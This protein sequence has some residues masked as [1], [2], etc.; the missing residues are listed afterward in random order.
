MPTENFPVMDIEI[1]EFCADDGMFPPSV[2]SQFFPCEAVETSTDQTTEP[3][4]P[5]PVANALALLVT[6]VGLNWA[7]ATIQVPIS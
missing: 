3:S 7:L 5:T 6:P 1:D 2:R 4:T